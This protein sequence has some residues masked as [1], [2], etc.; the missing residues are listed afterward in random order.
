[1]LVHLHRVSDRL[2][3]KGQLHTYDTDRGDVAVA[4]R[5]ADGH[6]ATGH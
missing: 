2:R 1:M 5:A 4:E 3:R 6:S